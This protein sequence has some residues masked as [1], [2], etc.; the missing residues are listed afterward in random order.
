MSDGNKSADGGA[1]RAVLARAYVAKSVPAIDVPADVLSLPIEKRVERAIGLVLLAGVLVSAA[2][3]LFGGAVY[4]SRH[5]AQAAQ[6]RVFVGE[7]SD[8]V[9]LSGVLDDVRKFSGRGIIQLG[10]MFLV[11][12]QVVRI[13]LAGVLFMVERDHIFVVITAVVFALLMYG[14]LF[15]GRLVH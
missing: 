14:L 10:L 4:I 3:V 13:M 15:E 1:A 12:V 2:F 5:G 9:S 7:P 8:L 11:G 6:Y